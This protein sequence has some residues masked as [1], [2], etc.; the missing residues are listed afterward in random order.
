MAASFDTARRKCSEAALTLREAS[1]EANRYAYW[2]TPGGSGGAAIAAKSTVADA[3]LKVGTPLDALYPQDYFRPGSEV[4][5]AL[6]R[7]VDIYGCDQ[8]EMYAAAINPYQASG[9]RAFTKNCISCSMAFADIYQGINKAPAL[10]SLSS[11]TSDESRLYDWA[12]V[13]AAVYRYAP[14]LDPSIIT[15]DIYTRIQ[16]GLA[17]L[18]R[19]TVAI[20]G[21]EFA[22][23]DL[24]GH[25]FN[26]Y[27]DNSSRVRW[28]DVQYGI[29]ENWPPRYVD[30]II[31]FSCI[32]RVPG[33]SWKEL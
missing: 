10:G 27:V 11:H 18:P 12:G 1:S 5:D 19:G 7:L 15:H 6:V 32:Y 24:G 23:P 33:D 30:N 21:T 29:I 25:A 26:A 4:A 31:N 16:S 2:L 14:E 22:N 17:A 28:A 20:I 9:T 3:S 13:H 8:P